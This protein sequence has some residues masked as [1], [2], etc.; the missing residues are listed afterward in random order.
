MLYGVV[1]KITCSETDKSYIGRTKRSL[2]KRWY[3]H[4]LLTS[5]C[6]LLKRAIEKYGKESFTITAIASSWNDENLGSGDTIN[7]QVLS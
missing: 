7:G 5:N 1:Y 2:R 6:L 4:C 3:D